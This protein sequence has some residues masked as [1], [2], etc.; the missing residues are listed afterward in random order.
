LSYC[1]WSKWICDKFLYFPV[2]LLIQQ[3]FFLASDDAFKNACASLLGQDISSWNSNLDMATVP[4]QSFADSS[5]A[6]I[7]ERHMQCI[8]HLAASATPSG[9]SRLIAVFDELWKQKLI[10]NF[11]TVCKT[12]TLPLSYVTVMSL[13]CQ[14]DITFR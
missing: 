5:H 8:V 14:A 6:D 7:V 13:S 9:S 4:F 1:Q 12:K 10:N 2:R 11:I 3:L